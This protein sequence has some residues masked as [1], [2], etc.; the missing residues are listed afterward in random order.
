MSRGWCFE[1]EH[2]DDKRVLLAKVERLI[3]EEE[4]G[5]DDDMSNNPIRALLRLNNNGEDSDDNNNNTSGGDGVENSQFRTEAAIEE[6]IKR[7]RDANIAEA[8]EIERIVESGHKKM[9][10]LKEE[11][12]KNPES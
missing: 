11:L 8:R 7:A 4:E 3:G 10:A 5:D 1:I 12:S 2:A 6:D 9:S